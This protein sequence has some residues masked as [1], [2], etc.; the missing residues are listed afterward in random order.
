MRK[1]HPDRAALPADLEGRLRPAP[2][3]GFQQELL[4]KRYKHAR[5]G[6]ED[7]PWGSRD[8]SIRDPFG[9]RLTFANK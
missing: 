6:I 2:L 9:N 5:P 8:M 4:A 3:E 7:M 1:N